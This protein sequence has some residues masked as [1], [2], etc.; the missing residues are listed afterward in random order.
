MCSSK[1]LLE[2]NR[3]PSLSPKEG[4][5]FCYITFTVGRAVSMNGLKIIFICDT[6][7]LSFFL[8]GFYFWGVARRAGECQ[9]PSSDMCTD[10]RNILFVYNGFF[11]LLLFHHSF[12]FPPPHSSLPPTLQPTPFRFVH[13]SFI[14]VP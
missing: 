1:E 5:C 4:V 6:Y 9:K 8:Q 7:V 13:V 14:R 10:F 2:E 11:F 3:A 12:H